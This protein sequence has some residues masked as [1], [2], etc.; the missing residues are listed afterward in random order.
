MPCPWPSSQLLV[1]T[2]RLSREALLYPHQTG[3]QSRRL[4]PFPVPDL[5]L[6]WD[7]NFF[8]TSA[9]LLWIGVRLE[10][11]GCFVPKDH[12]LRRGGNIM[13]V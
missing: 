7:I 6:L 3:H 10:P 8:Q 1:G 11:L 13:R 9:F 12:F 2:L 5:V 4:A